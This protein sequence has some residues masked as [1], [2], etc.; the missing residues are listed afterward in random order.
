MESYQLTSHQ[1]IFCWAHSAN[2]KLLS[3]WY[4]C[5]AAS[6][7]LSDCFIWS[8]SAKWVMAATTSSGFFTGVEVP[9]K[10]GVTGGAS[11]TSGA[12]G[13]SDA[14]VALPQ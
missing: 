5:K 11:A 4:F 12:A 10:G 1:A 2:L 6:A 8:S 13:L 3:L 14:A 7:P 9:L